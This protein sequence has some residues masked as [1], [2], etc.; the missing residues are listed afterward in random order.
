[1][2]EVDEADARVLRVVLG[3]EDLEMGGRAKGKERKGGRF[4]RHLSSSEFAARGL[5]FLAK[6]KPAD[7]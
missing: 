6:S 1:M 4:R 5:R 7:A 3:G 2:V